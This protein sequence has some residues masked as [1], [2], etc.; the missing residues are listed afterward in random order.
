M[1]SSTQA[2]QADRTSTVLMQVHARI[3]TCGASN[4]GLVGDA[5]LETLG[6]A[7]KSLEQE[8]EPAQQRE[9]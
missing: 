1:P 6:R 2:G 5:G 9:R 7:H 4:D 8:Q 3:M